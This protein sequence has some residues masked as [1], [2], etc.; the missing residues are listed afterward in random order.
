MR[1]GRSRCQLP[2]SNSQT[3]SCEPF[4]WELGVGRLGVDT[5]L[6]H[7]CY[8]PRAMRVSQL[9]RLLALLVSVA[10]A[11]PLAQQPAAPAPPPGPPPGPDS[12]VQPGT[13]TGEVI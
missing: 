6:F 3:S 11:A 7:A 8:A 12:Q 4:C 10:V 5:S 2:T 13:P 1:M 9:V